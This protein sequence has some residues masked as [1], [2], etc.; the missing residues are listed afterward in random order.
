MIITK[1]IDFF[2]N[3]T[4]SKTIDIVAVVSASIAVFAAIVSVYQARISKATY[5]LQSAIYNDG[6]PNLI[7]QE[8]EDSFLQNE[9]GLNSILY[10]LSILVCNLSDKPNALTSACLK[11]IHDNGEYIIQHPQNINIQELNILSVPV[12]ITPHGSVS[13]WLVFELPKIAYDSMNI[14]THYIAIRDV[15]DNITSREEI[16]IREELKGYDFGQ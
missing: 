16:F 8:V 15:H 12:N 13:G 3:L 11:I 14:D 2:V 4:V 6:Q 10:F 1:I 7:I 5:K 9:N